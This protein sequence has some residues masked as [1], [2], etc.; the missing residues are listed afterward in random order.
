MSLTTKQKAEIE[1]AFCSCQSMEELVILLNKINSWRHENLYWKHEQQVITV[2]NLKYYLYGK[3]NKYKVSQIPKKSGGTRTIKSPVR[4]LNMVQRLLSICLQACFTPMPTATGFVAGRSIVDNAKK[5]TNKKYVYNIDIKD[6]FPSISF[7]R[8]RAVLAKVPP[9]KLN[10]DI[11]H[12]LANLCCDENALPQGAPTSPVLSNLIC[13]RLDAKLWK[14]SQTENFIFSRYAD[15]ITISSNKN[16]FTEE[17]KK[18]IATII[19]E[20]GFELND[21]KERLQRYNVKQTDGTYLRERQ[22]VT[23]IIVNEKTNVSRSYLRNLRAVLHNWKNHG[24]EVANA[25]HLH[26]YTRE[27]GFQKY[28]GRIPAIEEVVGGK[29]E[30]LGM[31]RGKEDGTYRLMKL[32][33]DELCMK[34]DMTVDDFKTVFDLL[35]SKGVKKAAD[36][37]YNRRNVKENG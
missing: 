17:F 7:H 25:K 12:I 18:K 32:Q 9:F 24:Y 16:I 31:V 6:F 27:K 1:V 29:I 5:H 26:Y 33:F 28:N 35:E 2:K 36:F 23:G 34:Q 30:Y 11:A 20:E 14:L 21:K 3:E 15:D 10:D 8:I 22:E 13:K 4:F 37:F 19:Q